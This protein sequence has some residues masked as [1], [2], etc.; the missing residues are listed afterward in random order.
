M[1]QRRNDVFETPQERHWEFW[2]VDENGD[3]HHEWFK[4]KAGRR[5]KVE[6]F[7]EKNYLIKISTCLDFGV[8]LIEEEY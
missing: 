6:K 7:I 8:K 1:V 3:K 5:S 2:A 4:C